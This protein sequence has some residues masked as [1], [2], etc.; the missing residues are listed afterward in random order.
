MHL[1][2]IDFLKAIFRGFWADSVHGGEYTTKQ[3]TF[4]WP[5]D[6]YFNAVFRMSQYNVLYNVVERF[7]TK[8]R[9]FEDNFVMA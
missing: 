7:S 2:M 4:L 6:P 1:K 8:Y 5:A 3:E 9:F